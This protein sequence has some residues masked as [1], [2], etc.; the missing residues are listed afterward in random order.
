[1]RTT[2]PQPMRCRESV[3]ARR[4]GNVLWI[5]DQPKI[6]DEIIR[7]CTSPAAAPALHSRTSFKNEAF[8]FGAVIAW[9]FSTLL[10]HP[11]W[12]VV[13]PKLRDWLNTFGW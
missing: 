1:M 11:V 4:S 13:L 2:N 3:R 5:H 6:N 7:K 10:L 12:S 9:A 8:A